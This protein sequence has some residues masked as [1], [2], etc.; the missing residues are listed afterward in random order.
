MSHLFTLLLPTASHFSPSTYPPSFPASHSLPLL[1][2]Y[3]LPSSF[4][5]QSVIF[6]H[7]STASPTLT[8]TLTYTLTLNHTHTHNHCLPLSLST[9]Q[10]SYA[11][12]YT[13]SLSTWTTSQWPSSFF[14]SHSWV[15]WSAARTTL[16]PR[17]WPLTW[18]TIHQSRATTRYCT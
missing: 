9:P 12:C 7:S 6:S 5:P 13:S 3:L 8:L 16:S 11:L 2:P 15:A 17:P 18:P 14:S 1:P 10:A 4:F